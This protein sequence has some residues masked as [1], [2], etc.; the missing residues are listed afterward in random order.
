[1]IEPPVIF[2]SHGPPL[3]GV[4]PCPAHHFLKSLG[5]EFPV[6]RAILSI[7]AHWESVDP[8]VTKGQRPQILYDF[9]GLGVLR[10][11]SY[12]PAGLPELADEVVDRLAR[13]GIKAHGMDRGF[14]HGTWIPL[15]L[16]YPKA[17]IPVVQ[18]SI[19]TEADAAHHFEL[20]KLLSSL[21]QKGVFIMAS[22]GAVHNL[23]EV[24]E[25][26][27]DADPPAYVQEFDRWLEKRILSDRTADLLDFRR[28]APHAK[29]CHPYP[30][31]HLL[32][33]FVALGAARGTVAR[34]LHESFL[35][36]TLSMAA[37][38]W[39]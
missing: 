21:R 11:L 4:V 17:D 29:R 34:R 24:G 6:P 27:I 1:M 19:Q 37:Y 38:A 33:L 30:H 15:A 13:Q 3:V 12:R 28:R 22:G 18:L 5:T 26:A 8:L 31:E 16:I 10:Q 9:G 23:D 7:S 32:P 14:D 25:Y 2:L 39:A 20:G 36:G 35:F